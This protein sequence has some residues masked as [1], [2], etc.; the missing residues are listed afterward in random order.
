M[1]TIHGLNGGMTQFY[2]VRSQ[3]VSQITIFNKKGENGN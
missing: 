1:V 3:I 2:E